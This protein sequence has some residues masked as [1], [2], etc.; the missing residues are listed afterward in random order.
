MS[1]PAK[2]EPVGLEIRELCRTIGGQVILDHV[3]LKV[4]P[5]EVYVI[6]G[7]SGAGKS[8]LLRNVIGLEEP[9]SGEILVDGVPARQALA[10][11]KVRLAMVFQSGALFSSLTLRENLEFYPREHRQGT[12]A[13]IR[14]RCDAALGTL[15]LLEH[16]DKYPS[17][18]SG[19]MRKRAAIARALVMEANLLLY[20]EP[21]SELDPVR[22][23]QISELISEVNSRFNATSIVVSHDRDLA[24]A[25]GDRIALMAD[26]RLVHEGSPDDFRTPADPAVAAFMNPV[27]RKVG[28][29]A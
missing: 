7:S 14:A 2:Q 21:T 8:F 9:D 11:G 15:G 17:A 22:A 19:G 20:D 26:G 12:L 29:G 25:I 10:S 4:Q 5:G 18:L 24:L 27:I 1:A 6:M 16:A 13:E 3:S 28:H 23:A